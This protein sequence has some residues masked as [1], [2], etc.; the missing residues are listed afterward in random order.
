MWRSFRRER[1]FRANQIPRRFDQANQTIWAECIKNSEPMDTSEPL[2]S[3]G[4]N[5]D[6]IQ[7]FSFRTNDNRSDPF[8]NVSFA[9]VH[10]HGASF[11]TNPDQRL[12]LWKYPTDKA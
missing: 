4:V 12:S 1:G 9:Q 7:T 3:L 11:W 5:P 10:K 8:Q 6:P 2:N